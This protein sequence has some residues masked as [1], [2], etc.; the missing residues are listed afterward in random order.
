MDVILNEKQVDLYDAANFLAMWQDAALI[1]AHDGMV[2]MIVEH[3]HGFA[4][5]KNEW[6]DYLQAVTQ[7]VSTWKNIV[8]K[9]QTFASK[10]D[11]IKFLAL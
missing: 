2:T 5:S 9:I 7:D 6:M 11:A 4:T 3:C 1:T 8:V 10:K